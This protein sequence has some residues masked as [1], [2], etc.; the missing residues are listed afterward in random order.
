MDPDGDGIVIDEPGTVI[1]AKQMYSKIAID[2]FAIDE[3]CGQRVIDMWK[4]D[5]SAI[6]RMK[7]HRPYSSL[8]EYIPF[9]IRDVASRL[10]TPS[11]SLTNH[12]ADNYLGSLWH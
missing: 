10:V 8:E 4:A 11:T 6:I 7:N 9:R 3:S 5:V 2:L 12:R 1:G